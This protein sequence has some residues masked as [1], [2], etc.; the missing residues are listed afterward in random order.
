MAEAVLDASAILAVIQNEPGAS[1]VMS[2]LQDAVVLTVNYAEVVSKLV[3]RGA[4]LQDADAAVQKLALSIVDFDLDLARRTGALRAATKNR[5][6]SL[7]DRACI[8]L[9]E[10]QRA[11]VVTSDQRW[12]G[13]VPGIDVQLIR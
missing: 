11:T 5:G 3:E 12:A 9:G 13:A 4:T 2:A 1:V 7:G 10:R 6:L 8:A